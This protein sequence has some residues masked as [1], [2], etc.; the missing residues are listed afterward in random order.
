MLIQG[1]LTVVKGVVTAAQFLRVLARRLP[2][3]AYFVVDPPPG[4]VMTAA[5]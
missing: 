2:G 3:G 5:P 1:A 4:I